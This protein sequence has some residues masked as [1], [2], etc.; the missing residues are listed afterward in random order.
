M[1]TGEKSRKDV[2]SDFLNNSMEP[3]M[4]STLFSRKLLLVTAVLAAT[5]GAV[6]VEAGGGRYR[7]QQDN[8]PGWTLMTPA[9]RTEFQT[10]MR[11]A[12]T[13]DECKAILAE[14]HAVMEARAKE[15]GVTLNAPRY[16]ACDQMKARGFLK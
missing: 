13:Y 10:K 1:R 7:F 6:S 14:H 12:K 2:F 9:E 5:L 3:I 8:T 4:K 16:N 15:K 11:A